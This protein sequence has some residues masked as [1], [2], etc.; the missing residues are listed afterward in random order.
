MGWGGGVNEGNILSI[1]N[2]ETQS[3]IFLHAHICPSVSSFGAFFKF[4]QQ[5]SNQYVHVD[6]AI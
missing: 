4:H 6:K 2:L 3:H 1:T 5:Y